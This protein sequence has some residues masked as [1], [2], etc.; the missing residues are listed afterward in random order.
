MSK[1]NVLKRDKFLPF[2]QISLAISIY[3]R[4]HSAILIYLSILD[5]H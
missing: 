5:K 2:N 4:V 1:S 3:T